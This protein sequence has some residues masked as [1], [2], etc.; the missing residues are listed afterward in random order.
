VWHVSL[1][2]MN[3]FNKTEAAIFPMQALLL[4]N[5]PLFSDWLKHAAVYH[6]TYLNIYHGKVKIGS[7]FTNIHRD[8]LPFFNP[9]MSLFVTWL[10]GSNKLG[11]EKVGLGFNLAFWLFGIYL[12][13]LRVGFCVGRYLSCIKFLVA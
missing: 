13:Q 12:F 11:F 7:V 6:F 1:L 2:L 10:K 4:E 3:S 9:V 5:F 8:V